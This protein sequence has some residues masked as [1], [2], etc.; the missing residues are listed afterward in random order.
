MRR[1]NERLHRP[2]LRVLTR[3]AREVCEQSR[4]ALEILSCSRDFDAANST[5]P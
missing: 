1:R 3:K 5:L 2:D 4:A